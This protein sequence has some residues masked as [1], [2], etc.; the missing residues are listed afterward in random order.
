MNN[1]FVKIFIAIHCSLFIVHCSFADDCL[2]YKINT[3]V[4][5]IVPEFSVQTVQPAQPMDLLHGNVISTL[6]ENYELGAESA[7]VPGGFC[8]YLKSVSGTIG[9]SDFLVQIDSRHRPGSCGYDMTRA[10]EQEHIDAHLSVIKDYQDKI[11]AAIG[12]AADSVMPVF[13]R[14]A[15]D[16]DAALDELNKKIQTHPDVVL[17]KQKIAAEEEIRNKRI[18]QNDPGKRISECTR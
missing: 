18:D 13:V 8:V 1:F 17:L 16:Q 10:H 15:A 2:S 14:T 5:I 3:N 7:E 12:A 9:Y 6:S 4:K 11:A